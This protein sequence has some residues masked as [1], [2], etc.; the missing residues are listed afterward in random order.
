MSQSFD[1]MF[2]HLVFST[3]H[4]SPTIR[5]TWADRMYE[6][7]GGIVANRQGKL[8]AANGMSDHV[9]L[10][11]SFGRK[12]SLADLLRD[13]KAGSSKWVHD[14]F[15]EDNAF[16]WQD[17]YG[18]FSVSASNLEDAK[19]YIADQQRHHQK[20]TFQEEL[21]ILLRKHGLTWDDRYIW[22]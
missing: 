19:K 10:L 6:Y 18:A 15:A 22:D 7:I 8:L 20:M 13:I 14:N 3:K 9:H 4:R 1:A 12:W 17:G 16:G 5:P 2:V 21:L 11:V